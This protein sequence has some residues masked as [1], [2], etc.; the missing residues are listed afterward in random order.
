MIGPSL[1]RWAAL[2]LVLIVADVSGPP[3]APPGRTAK[4][5]PADSAVPAAARPP[6]ESVEVRLLLIGDPGDPAPGS[7]PVLAALA[8]RA[9]QGPVARTLILFLGDIVYPHGLPDSTDPDRAEAERRLNA[10][11]DVLRS[12]GVRGL[13]VPGN[14]DWDAH[15]DDGWQAVIR[16]G[17]YIEAHSGG[18]FALLP[19][20]GCPGPAIVDLGTAVRLVLLDT[21]WWLHEG[22]KPEGPA[23]GC[24]VASQQ[25]VL[26]SLRGALRGAGGRHVA[27]VGHH[28]LESGGPHGGHFGW[29]AHIFPLRSV[30]SWLWIPLPGLGSIYPLA[31]QQGVSNQDLSGPRY[32]RLRAGLDS[33]FAEQPPLVYASGHDHSLQVLAGETARYLV[34]SGSGYYGHASRVARLDHTRFALE[35]S[36]Y[37]Q[38]DVVKSGRVRLGVLVVDQAGRA[39][40]AFS[41][42]LD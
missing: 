4:P 23:S 14:H 19:G 40:E 27:V 35:A 31:R 33:V 36:G 37:M 6:P 26:D 17:R 11:L 20:G 16:L 24:A 32:R 38:L 12:T 2:P 8:A 21:Q 28:A 39:T 41:M 25:A 22:P 34:V 13:F 29:Q 9:A 15:G 30:N 18:R 42:W 5:L 3:P 7:E 10:Q 1:S